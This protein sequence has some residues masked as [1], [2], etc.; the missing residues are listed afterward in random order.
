[1]CSTSSIDP[2]RWFAGSAAARSML[3]ESAVNAE[4][5]PASWRKRRRLTS[6]MGEGPLK[7]KE[8]LVRPVR[9]VMRAQG[10]FQEHRTSGKAPVAPG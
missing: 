8:N 1:M 10:V 9:V 3:P 6:D 4:V 5:A 7:R 2:V